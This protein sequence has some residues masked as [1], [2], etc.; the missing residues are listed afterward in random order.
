MAAR[1]PF[2][3]RHRAPHRSRAFGNFHVLVALA[4]LYAHRKRRWP[5]YPLFMLGALAGV[6]WW[7]YSPSLPPEMLTAR[8][9]NDRSKFIYIGG[10][11]AHMRDQGNPDGTPLVLIHGAGGSLHVWE[12]WAHELGSKARLISVDLPGHG[13]TGA[14]PR[15]EYTVE[16]YADFI[17][18]LVDALNLDRFVLAGHSLGGAVAWTF[19]ATRPGR[20]SQIILVDAAGENRE[21]P[22]PTRLARLPVVGDIGIY[23]KPEQWVRRKLTEAYADPVMVTAMRVKRIAELQRFPGNRE[24]TL[25]RARTQG[26]LDPTPLKRL[27]VPTLILWGAQDRWVSVADAFQFLNDIKTAKLEIFEHLGHNPMEEDPKAT[28]AAVA[29]FLKPILIRPAPAPLRTD[30]LATGQLAAVPSDVP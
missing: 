9:S 20:L 3:V 22:W 15:N 26:P 4:R 27:T 14:W 21:A 23:F 16:A 12:G 5:F 28:A 10:V 24:A 6:A 29:A 1:G 30:P 13:L 11:R 18:L 17:E 2:G 19:A 8:Y 25:L 7:A